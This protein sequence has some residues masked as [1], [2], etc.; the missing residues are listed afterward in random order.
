MISDKILSI[1]PSYTV[2]ISLK[3]KLLKDSGVN[4]LDLS[5]GEP[6]FN[7]PNIAKSYGIDSLN[8]NLT[9]YDSVSGLSI[10][11]DEICK[12][13]FNDNNCSYSNDEIVISSGAKHAITNTLLALVNPTDQ[14]LIPKPYWV[15]Y[16]EIVKLTGGIPI[17]IDSSKEN[18]FKITA[19]SLSKYITNKTKLLILN[20]PCNPTGSLYT[21]DELSE[22]ATICVKNNIYIL[23]DEIYEKICFNDNFVSMASISDKVKDLTIII[24]GFSKSSCMTGLRVAYSASNKTIAKAISTIQSH[25]VSHPSLTSQYIAYGYLKE[26]SSYTNFMVNEYKKRMLLALDKLSYIP[27]IS[28][29]HPQ[30]AFYVFINISSFKNSINYESSFSIKFCD[31]FLE[32]Y[33]TAIVP[34][35][36]FGLD[37][38]IRISFACDESILLDGINRLHKFINDISIRSL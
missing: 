30:G 34:G 10:L 22:I 20:N 7:I 1:A 17:F 3:T 15:S 9:R 5:V 14:V 26:C 36:A 25:L 27:H 18:N 16:P 6:N 24:N 4:V 23:C 33:K 8:L 19:S 29:I 31:K 28:Y 37:D 38:Y 13:L 2:G 12:K 21:K 32:S 11:K 35:I